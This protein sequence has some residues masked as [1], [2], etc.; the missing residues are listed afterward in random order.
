MKKVLKW[1]GIAVAVV[2]LVVGGFLTYVA[3]TGI[4]SYDVQKIEMRVTATPERLARGTALATTLCVNCHLDRKT[5]GLTGEH[6]PDLPEQFGVA[7]SRNITQDRTYGIGAWSDGDIAWL[8]RTGVHPK[9]GR[10]LP[11]WMPKFAHMSDEDIKSI[12][13]FLRSNDPLVAAQPVKNRDSEPSFFA[14]FLTHVAFK[15]LPYPTKPI[16][17]PDTNDL[18]AYGKYAATGTYDCYI[19]HSADIAD[20]NIM[21]PHATPGFMG[22]GTLMPDMNGKQIATSNITFDNATGIGT[23]TEDQFATALREGIR[24]DGRVIR[25]PM[26]GMSSI[27]DREARAIYAYLKSVPKLTNKVPAA[28]TY[29]D[30]N[31]G[32]KGR[33]AYYKYE[34]VRCHGVDGK[35]IAD[36]T[37]ASTKYPADSTLMDVIANPRKYFPTTIM[38]HWNGRI[39]ASDIA[40]LATYV[41][42]LGK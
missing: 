37:V 38:P 24:P 4:P 42:T 39:P 36:I 5:G 23:W 21:E 27:T 8:L 31:T 9:T 18:L 10:Y 26:A 6:M 40:E 25:Y 3:V 19:C 35:G 33:Q 15:P 14:K 32:S 22:G 11:P 20:I 17:H 28:E 34:C 30:A 16:P 1:L 7:Y 41:R 12:I 29:A 2:V 13:T